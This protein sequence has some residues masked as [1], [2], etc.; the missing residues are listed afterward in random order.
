MSTQFKLRVTREGH[1]V[2]EMNV[3]VGKMNIWSSLEVSRSG[4]RGQK[5]PRPRGAQ[6]AFHR[7]PTPPPGLHLA[8]EYW[9]DR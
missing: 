6:A 4:R 1:Q 8:I 7:F 5:S 9:V 2:D 3:Q